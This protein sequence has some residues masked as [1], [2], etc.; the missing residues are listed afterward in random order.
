[1]PTRA[2]NW[3]CP[4]IAQQIT[5]SFGT[6]INKDVVRRVL[7]TYYHPEPNAG[8]PSWL[9]F[10]GHMK[11]SLWSVDLFGVNLLYYEPIGFSS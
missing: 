4:R 6:E 11:D 8:G 9:T 3:G 1:M 10:I 7:A 2:C 5:L